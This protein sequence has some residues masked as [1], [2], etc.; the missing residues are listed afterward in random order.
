MVNA[1]KTAVTADAIKPTKIAEPL[2]PR[3]VASPAP[4]PSYTV[5]AP[6][7][8]EP[9]PVPTNTRTGWFIGGSIV[10]ILIVLG[11]VAV[12]LKSSASPTD[13]TPLPTLA[14]L[15][16]T[17]SP[18]AVTI[19]AVATQSAVPNS[20]S[21]LTVDQA[22][23]A[24]ANSS[25]DPS[26][27]IALAKAA[28]QQNETDVA[29]QAIQDGLKIAPNKIDF[30][31]T[32]GK[33]AQDLNR[34]TAMVILD[35]QGLFRA[36]S[37]P[38]IYD[39]VR[40]QVGQALYRAAQMPDQINL[41]EIDRSNKSTPDFQTPN[42]F[43]IMTV[44]MLVVQR[45]LL[46]AQTAYN[47]LSDETSKLPEAYLVHGELLQAQGSLDKAKKEWKAVLQIPDTPQWVTD[48]V[49]ELLKSN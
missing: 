29:Q 8:V 12:A 35:T 48:R 4:I 11:L 43:D 40:A 16:V 25:N 45:R 39:A 41:R 24:V 10:G 49:T 44:Q 30:L 18:P 31:L 17:A 5:G 42:L 2:S 36:E 19:T 15:N 6:P 7:P 23:T 38:T 9:L 22:Q 27:Y 14:S 3:T 28:W 21:F 1:F 26:A 32:A 13:E 33:L 46:L 20:E 37:Q 34:L 47:R